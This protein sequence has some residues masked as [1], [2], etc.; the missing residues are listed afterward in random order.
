MKSG[1]VGNNTKI[2]S[3]LFYPNPA[4]NFIYLQDGCD[5]NQV[6]VMDLNG[7]L[8]DVEMSNNLLDISHLLPGF[9]IMEMASKGQTLQQKMIKL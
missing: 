9:Y 2:F 6:R 8:Q 7:K 5:Q 4:Q 3:P 1:L